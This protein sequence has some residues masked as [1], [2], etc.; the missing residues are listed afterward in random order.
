MSR[1]F[2]SDYGRQHSTPMQMERSG[3]ALFDFPAVEFPSWYHAS[4]IPF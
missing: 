3:K 2:G 1:T 4:T